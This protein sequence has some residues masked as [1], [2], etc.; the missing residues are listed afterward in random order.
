MEGHHH[1][2]VG[3][4]LLSGL[5]S[6]SIMDSDLTS[7]STQKS[8]IKSTTKVIS[9]TPKPTPK[10]S[11]KPASS[12]PCNMTM[13]TNYIEFGSF[14]PHSSGVSARWVA[15]ERDWYCLELKANLSASSYMA[16][17]FTN[18]GMGPAPVV[19]C[20]ADAPFKFPLYWNTA[21]NSAPTYNTSA[22]LQTTVNTTGGTTT[23][24][25]AIS[26]NFYVFPNSSSSKPEQ[27]DLNFTPYHLAAA[28]GPVTNGSL[29]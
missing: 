5:A 27:F 13:F 23:C 3:L 8:T 11:P 6:S 15:T 22:S 28:S 1:L 24:Y 29:T 10:P 16:L 20:S 7:S 21:F 2:L 17:G 18:G 9:P 25:I 26:S 14:E 19:A 12:N 4:L